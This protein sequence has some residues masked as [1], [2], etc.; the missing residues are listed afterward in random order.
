MASASIISWRL[1]QPPTSSPYYNPHTAP[2]FTVPQS[3]F[4]YAPYGYVTSTGSYVYTSMASP[5]YVSAPTTAAT[6]KVSRFAYS[7]P[8]PQYHLLYS[9]HTGAFQTSGPASFF[10]VGMG[11][12]TFLLNRVVERKLFE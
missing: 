9:Q 4:A 3:T 10:L 2:P 8:A 1:V 11:P 12:T 6:T 7:R 5:Y